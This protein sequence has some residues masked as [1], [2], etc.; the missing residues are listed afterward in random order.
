VSASLYDGWREVVEHLLVELPVV[1]LHFAPGRQHVYG[2]SLDEMLA[3]RRF[4]TSTFAWED[5]HIL[6][7]GQDTAAKLVDQ[8]GN[9]VETYEYDP[10]GMPKVFVGSSTTPQNESSVGLVHLWKGLRWDAMIGQ[11]YM[12][13]RVY[14]PETGRFKT[15]DPL[16]V[17]TDFG[18]MGNEYAYGW[19]RPLVVGDPLGLQAPQAEAPEAPT[20]QSL[21]LDHQIVPT[22][23]GPR[24]YKIVVHVLWR[25]VLPANCWEIRI[26]IRGKKGGKTASGAPID[27][28]NGASEIPSDEERHRRGAK[29]THRMP[30]PDTKSDTDWAMDTYGGSLLAE[31][32]GVRGALQAGGNNREAAIRSNWAFRDFGG[33]LK[34]SNR[35][36]YDRVLDKASGN[37]NGLEYTYLDSVV[38]NYHEGD[39]VDI[40]LLFRMVA[41]HRCDGSE[42]VLSKAVVKVAGVITNGKL[43]PP[44][45]YDCWHCLRLHVVLCVGVGVIRL[46]GW[47]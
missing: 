11:Y 42:V 24:D 41:I 26:D 28:T 20:G 1:G 19:N 39:S 6:H 2:D 35:E 34:M 3:F 17:H 5:Y 30:N 47:I 23:Y 27:E 46:Q 10:Y 40:D 44:S 45:K 31:D 16:G 32:N 7:G 36:L 9:V 4:N 12:R 29:S 13:N 15:R 18:N 33:K 25:A 8:N 14:D 43:V 22:R 21:V 38:T 37:A